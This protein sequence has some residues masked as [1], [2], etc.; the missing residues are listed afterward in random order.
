MKRFYKISKMLLKEGVLKETQNTNIQY[1]PSIPSCLLS[2]LRGKK[3][4]IK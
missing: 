1:L 4:R 3:T 2:A